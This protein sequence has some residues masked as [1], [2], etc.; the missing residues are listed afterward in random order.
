VNVKTSISIPDTIY[1]A[2]DALAKRLGIS[3]SELY[4]R[5][6]AQYV[7]KHD[8]DRFTER[9]NAVYAEED[10]SLDSAAVA[11]RVRTLPPESW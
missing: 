3:R 1:E 6:L 11:A 2:G 8:V 4:G 7:A 5:A 10:S 9:L